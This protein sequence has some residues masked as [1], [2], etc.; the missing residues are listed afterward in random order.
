MF[1][2]DH[3][4][5]SPCLAE[6]SARCVSQAEQRSPKT[7]LPTNRGSARGLQQRPRPRIGHL[8][9]AFVPLTQPERGD[10][11]L[12]DTLGVV[13][14]CWHHGRTPPLAGPPAASLSDPLP[15]SCRPAKMVAR[16]INDTLMQVEHTPPVHKKVRGGP[17]HAAAA[18]LC[19]AFRTTEISGTARLG[20]QW[21]LLASLVHISMMHVTSLPRLPSLGRS[22]IWTSPATAGMA[23]SP[24]PVG[25]SHI[26]SQLAPS[27]KPTPLT[28][29]AASL[30]LLRLARPTSKPPLW[31]LPCRCWMCCRACR[32]VS[33]AL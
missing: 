19:A 3:S 8:S 11:A 30:S 21:L 24:P 20:V 12:G 23:T 6:L 25:D 26:A 22:A 18:A 9:D 14:A 31:P 10:A 13:E 33:R 27:P 32:A 4:L 15:L 1:S 16:T 17:P 2:A 29:S 5:F 7:H 28:P